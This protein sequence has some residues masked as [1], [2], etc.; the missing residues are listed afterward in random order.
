MPPP[1]ARDKKTGSVVSL[2]SK[3]LIHYDTHVTI[4]HLRGASIGS[5]DCLVR[6]TVW[7]GPTILQ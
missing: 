7:Q 2:H 1:S 4:A 6:V 3:S 5:E